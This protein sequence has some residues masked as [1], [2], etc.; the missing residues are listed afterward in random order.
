MYTLFV[1]DDESCIVS[2]EDKR[3]TANCFSKTLQIYGA[4][5]LRDAM[6]IDLLLKAGIMGDEKEWRK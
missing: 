6:R 4:E 5:D 2:R 3:L 1:I